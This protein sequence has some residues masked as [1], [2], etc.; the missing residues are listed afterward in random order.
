MITPRI[1]ILWNQSLRSGFLT[2]GGLTV[3]NEGGL[4]LVKATLLEVGQALRFIRQIDAG[5]THVME[6]ETA[7][8]LGVQEGAAVILLDKEHRGLRGYDNE[9]VLW[10]QVNDETIDAL[11]AIP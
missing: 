10:A 5:I 3:L 9:L 6:G 1:I 7:K 8:V 4:V 2:S 11:E